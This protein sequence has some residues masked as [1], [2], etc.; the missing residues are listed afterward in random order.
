MFM[1]KAWDIKG[2]LL[3]SINSQKMGLIKTS[4]L[5]SDRSFVTITLTIYGTAVCNSSLSPV[6]D[7]MSPVCK[8]PVNASAFLARI[9]CNSKKYLRP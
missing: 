4:I 6:P 3:L 7:Y 1:F 9:S 2:I 5:A 8:N